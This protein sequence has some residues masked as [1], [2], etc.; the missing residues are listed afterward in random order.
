MASPSTKRPWIMPVADP[1]WISQYQEAAIDPDVRI[2]DAHHHLWV[3]PN[4]TY[5]VP[6]FLA[7]AGGGHHIEASV[8]MEGSMA[9]R[10]DGPEEMRS[11]G[12][13]EFAHA[14]AIETNARVSTGIVAFANLRTS[15]N[16]EAILSAHIDAGGGRLRG[17]RDIL[18]WDP[19][20]ELRDPRIDPEEHA[21]DMPA[22]RDSLRLLGTHDLVFDVWLYFTQLKKL[23]EVARDVPETRIVI[24]HFGGPLG[25]GGY[26]NRRDEVIAV[27]NDG[28]KALSACPNVYMKIG[29]LAGRW[30][31]LGFHELAKP[32]SSEVMA[33]AWLP[34]VEPTIEAF[35]AARCMF[36]S[37]FPVD[38]ETC[39]YVTLW[40]TFKRVARR[41]SS[42]EREALFRGTAIQVYRLNLPEA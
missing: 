41:Y 7:D 17:I 40:N 2:I 8:Y 18:A 31:G 16:L 11:V 34:Y 5:L 33:K 21:M 25:V 24:N 6:D 1:D 37:N 27:W 4:Q 35:G 10:G 9:Y 26:R 42:A 32:P 13:T 3:L 12:E 19:D 30:A 20:I 38:A 14:A 15:T 29:G 36:E 23:A 22:F 28:L 39:S